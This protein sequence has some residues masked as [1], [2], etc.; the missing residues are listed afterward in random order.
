M[1]PTE[2]AAQS[3]PEI[4]AG[5]ALVMVLDAQRQIR[6]VNPALAQLAGYDERELL[7]QPFPLLRHSETPAD[8]LR[9]MWRRVAAGGTW[10]APVALR[11][12]GGAALWVLATCM[13][14]HHARMGEITV[15]VLVRPSDWQ[16]LAAMERYAVMRT[17]ITNWL[18]RLMFE[19]LVLKQVLRW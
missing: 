17:R 8:V 2:L 13:P 9:E 14:M 19:P 7:G 10:I 15:L 11:C 4:D 1:K 18:D 3:R 16:V 12:R 5:T 6:C